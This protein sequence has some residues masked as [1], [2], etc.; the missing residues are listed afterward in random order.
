AFR[1]RDRT[2][3]K[4]NHLYISEYVACKSLTIEYWKD[5]VHSNN[6]QKKPPPPQQQQQQQQSN[7]QSRSDIRMTIICNDDA[8]FQIS[9][10]PP[11][12]IKDSL[13][14]DKILE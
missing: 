6:I 7:V 1:I 10:F 11:L 14:I 4:Q 8:K 2:A 5:Y 12:S 3:T 9:H 13:A